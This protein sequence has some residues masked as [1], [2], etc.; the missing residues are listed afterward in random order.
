[1]LSRKK[2]A[3]ISYS[4]PKEPVKSAADKTGAA[5]SHSQVQ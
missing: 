1:M 3:K 5:T 4:G 2:K